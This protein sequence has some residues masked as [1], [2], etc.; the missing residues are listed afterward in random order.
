MPAIFRGRPFRRPRRWLPPTKR[1]LVNPV[2]T[3]DPA[4]YVWT[5]QAVTLAVAMPATAASY[6]WTAQPAT[7]RVS[8]PA[9]AAA[10]TWTAQPVTLAVGFPATAAAYVWTA[11]PVTLAV[12]MPAGSASYVWS[13]SDAALSTSGAFTLAA[14]AAAY[15]WTAQSAGSRRT[16]ALAAGSVAYVWTASDA[17]LIYS[18]APVP[19]G[20]GGAGHGGGRRR[21]FPFPNRYDDPEF[22][23]PEPIREPEPEREP[24][25]VARQPYTE[26]DPVSVPS[27]PSALSDIGQQPI[28]LKRPPEVPAPVVTSKPR[29][30]DVA[31]VAKVAPPPA[32][33]A[34][35][36]PLRQVPPNEE[37]EMH[38]L[39]MFGFL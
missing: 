18:A 14:S 34:K 33:S 11:Q 15:I 26:G 20:G 4:A 38:I 35:P 25:P 2:L 23:R 31:K 37:E 19:G 8:M 36:K 5:A 6:T 27:G 22:F 12:T 30:A 21:H 32:T 24:E 16:Y 10:Y 28:R 1:A 39:R 13:P 7:L 17:T 3:A 29:K 9:T